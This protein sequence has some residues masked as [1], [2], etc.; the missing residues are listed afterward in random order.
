[1]IVT[2]RRKKIPGDPKERRGRKTDPITW[3]QNP[4]IRSSLREE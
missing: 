1:M 3:I 2:R 4:E